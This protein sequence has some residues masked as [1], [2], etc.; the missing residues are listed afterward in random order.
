MSLPR[1]NI[2]KSGD[3]I[4]ETLLSASTLNL[5]RVLVVDDVA[6]N[7]EIFIMHLGPA[8]RHAD[9]AGD[10]AAALELFKRHRYD[11]VLMDIEM[12]GID[13]YG[14]M[15]GMRAW[16]REHRLPQTLILAITSSDFPEDEQRIMDAGA[17]A[18]L[19]KPVKQ[20]DIML[21]LRLHQYPEPTPHPMAHLLPRMFSYAT[22]MLDE[23]AALDDREAISRSLHQLRGMIAVYG[24][25]DF[26]ERLRQVHSAVQQ[27][28]MPEAATFAQ[29]RNELLRLKEQGQQ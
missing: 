21:A 4:P 1:D 5:D 16:E 20:Q 7:R 18:Y 10:G 3:A 11:A 2:I 23:V 9:E 14:A 25:T 12:P 6:L 29:L 27:G 24:F 13:G 8:V 19:V 26:A 22:A 17:T 15:I 28:R